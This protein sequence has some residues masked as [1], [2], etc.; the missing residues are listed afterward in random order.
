MLDFVND[1]NYDVDTLFSIDDE[2]IKIRA[3]KNLSL[4]IKNKANRPLLESL[5]KNSDLHLYRFIIGNVGKN[6]AF[7]IREFDDVIIKYTD[8]LHE[9]LHLKNTIILY[10]R[11]GDSDILLTKVISLEPSLMSWLCFNSNMQQIRI[12]SILRSALENIST[13]TIDVISNDQQLS[14]AIVEILF[15]DLD[16]SQFTLAR[17]LTFASVPIDKAVF[18]LS[19][20]KIEAIQSIEKQLATDFISKAIAEVTP[21]NEHGVYEMLIEMD[22]VETVVLLH[23]LISKNSSRQIIRNIKSL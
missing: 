19:H 23:N 12:E 13:K 21:Q 9:Y 11:G 1:Q 15:S 4:F 8:I 3:K 17:V 5:L 22:Q 14:A 16:R 20:L 7:C 18:I 10:D 2:K 6:T